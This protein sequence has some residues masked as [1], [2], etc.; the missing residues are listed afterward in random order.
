MQNF[1]DLK[2]IWQHA[3]QG[4]EGHRLPSFDTQSETLHYKLKLQKQQLHA[5]I[6]LFCTGG[7]ILAMAFFGNLNFQSKITY[8]GMFLIA[9]ICFAQAILLL[10]TWKKIKKIDETLAPSAHLQQWEQYYI[11]RKHQAKWNMPVYFISLN[12]AMGLYLWE[13]FKGR[14]MLYVIIFLAI[15]TGWMLF[16]IFYLGKKAKRKENFRLNGI[17]QNL[18]KLEAQLENG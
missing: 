16:A 12:L 7:L 14:P 11:F 9:A 6:M 1:N 18:K 17:I 2:D 4:T 15:Y 8:L 3:G 13:I 5:G 10:F